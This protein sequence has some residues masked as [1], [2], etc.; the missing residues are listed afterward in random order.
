MQRLGYGPDKR[1]AVKVSTRDIPPY[2][3]PSVVLI[4]QLKGIYVD[5]EL[6]TIELSREE[7]SYPDL[8][9]MHQASRLLG[10]DEVAYVVL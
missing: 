10:A 6:E 3:D 9:R 2:R 1:L 7:L 8:V 4:D 5:A